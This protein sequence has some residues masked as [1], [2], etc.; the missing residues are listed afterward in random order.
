MIRV[1]LLSLALASPAAAETARV[2]SGEHG[3]F[4]R[5]VIELPSAG[6][7]TVGRTPLGYAFAALSPAQPQYDLSNVWQRIAQTRLRSLQVD[8]ETGAL[9]LELGC[10]CHVF[11]FEYRPGA[12]V[13][14]IKPGRPP[15]ASVFEAEFAS[16]ERKATAP[17]T[18]AAPESY[19]WLT[20]IQKPTSARTAAGL[21]LPLNTGTVSLDPLRNELL[22]GI[23]RGAADG[24]VD[25]EL[26]GRPR[27]VATAGQ[28]N[29]PW[30]RIRI[31][32]GPGVAVADADASEEGGTPMSN[33]ASDELVDLASWG[34]STPANDLLAEARSDLFGE[35]DQPD[36]DAVLRSVRLHLYLGFGAEARQHADFLD[37][38]SVTGELAL[39]RSMARILDG[40]SDPRTPFAAMLDCDGPAAL[41]A[42]LAHDRLPAGQGVNRDAV[43]QAFL[44]LPPHLRHHLGPGLAERFLDF[45][46]ADAARLI[47]DTI[48]RTPD[49]RLADVALLDA[50]AELHTGNIDAAQAHAEQALSLDGDNPDGLVALV[51][52]HFRKLEPINPTVVDALLAFQAETKGTA[53]AEGIMRALVLALAL[54]GQTDAAFVQDRATGDMLADLWRVAQDRATDDEFLRHAVLAAGDPR[55]EVS[56]DVALGVATRLLGLGF[57]DASLLWIGPVA[58]TDTPERRLATAAAK[59]Q[60]G[61]ARSA[62]THLAGLNDPEGLALRAKALVQL[63]EL[64]A[65]GAAL[66]AV[67]NADEVARLGLWSGNWTNLDPAT[68][69]TWV[70]AARHAGPGAVADDPGLL[71]RGTRTADESLAAREAIETLLVSVPSPTDG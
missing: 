10:E 15:T 45:D 41:W 34:G 61:D 5:L 46:D 68:P 58:A 19:R 49:A 8:P 9:E 35:F 66:A 43:I 71:A 70:M 27:D 54:S 57:A 38:P 11:P 52:A 31:G 36:T 62:L 56:P 18:G 2:L 50:S 55:P 24:I 26:P 39:Y 65:A 44:A 23:A 40:E 13:L 14:D 30:S 7:W 22:K 37:D 20:E 21:P 6:D 42:A 53:G 64:S 29:L 67:G 60:S 25:M 16:A 28:G 59:L 17:D 69:E 47:R 3:D 48:E 4:T 32:D 1:F 33:C 63:G 51:E 12:I